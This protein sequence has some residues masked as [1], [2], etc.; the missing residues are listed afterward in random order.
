[1][2][3]NKYTAEFYSKTGKKKAILTG[4]VNVV[5]RIIGD[6]LENLIKNNNLQRVS[7]TLP[8]N[9]IVTITKYIPINQDELNDTNSSFKRN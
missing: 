2:N 7:L 3:D 4:N 1:M 6:D 9:S 8:N 5:T